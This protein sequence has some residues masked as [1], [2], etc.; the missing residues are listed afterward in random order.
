MLSSSSYSSSYGL[1]L[2]CDAGAAEAANADAGL[3]FGA[4]R[5][6]V[7]CISPRYRTAPSRSLSRSS[8][9]LRERACNG[10]PTLSERGTTRRFVGVRSRSSSRLRTHDGLCIRT[11]AELCVRARTTVRAVIVVIVL[12]LSRVH[13]S[14]VAACAPPAFCPVDGAGVDD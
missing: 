1:R 8:K 4:P 9:A 12:P 3:R 5:T 10:G 11:R 6:F 14:T 13:H 2:L 7:S